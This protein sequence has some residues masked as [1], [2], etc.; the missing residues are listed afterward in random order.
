M[1]KITMAINEPPIR[2]FETKGNSIAI[3]LKSVTN[4]LPSKILF[5]E[6]SGS[7]WSDRG[8]LIELSDEKIDGDNYA[9]FN[10][11]ERKK[12]QSIFPKKYN[13]KETKKARL[14]KLPTKN[15]VWIKPITE[16]SE[17]EQVEKNLREAGI[18][19]NKD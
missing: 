18:I 14:V 15:S 16:D 5:P 3:N 12:V 2:S 6:P 4:L 11:D 10:S 17:P 19:N 8:I 13:L 7:S 1:V 9:Y